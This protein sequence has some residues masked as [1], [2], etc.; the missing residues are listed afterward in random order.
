MAPGQDPR[1]FGNAPGT[2]HEQNTVFLL[3]LGGKHLGETE[4]GPLCFGRF[5]A[6]VLRSSQGNE[7]ADR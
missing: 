2:S 5:G 6:Q 1:I 3:Q 7:G 4:K